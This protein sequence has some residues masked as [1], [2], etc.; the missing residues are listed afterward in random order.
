MWVPGSLAY[1][2]AAFAAFY[3][4]LAPGVTQAPA[5]EPRPEELSW[6]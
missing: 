3:R 4:W 2:V 6:T 5:A 1:F